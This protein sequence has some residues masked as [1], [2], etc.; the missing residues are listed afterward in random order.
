M[1]DMVNSILP[2]WHVFV[3]MFYFLVQFLFA[4]ILESFTCSLV[5]IVE[6]TIM[7]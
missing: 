4:S 5:Q 3:T 6:V 2:S 1:N 7:E